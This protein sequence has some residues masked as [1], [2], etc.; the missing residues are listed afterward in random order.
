MVLRP[1]ALVLLAVLSFTSGCAAD[2]DEDEGPIAE[3][4]DELRTSLEDVTILTAAMTEPGTLA[5]TY[6]PTLYAP[7]GWNTARSRV[8]YLA[9]E[10]PPRASAAFLAPPTVKV[11][12]DFP[13]SPDIVVTDASFRALTTTRGRQAVGGIEGKLPIV[14]SR[15][16][17]FVLVRDL[18]WVRPM[19]FHVTVGQ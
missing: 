13:G 8:P 18:L 10:L 16:K 2:E 15:G 1:H 5:V 9:I 11:T 12:G 17:K 3:A 6:E 19:T 7:S 4:Q 14:S